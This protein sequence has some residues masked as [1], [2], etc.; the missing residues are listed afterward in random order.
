[1]SGLKFKNSKDGVSRATINV[2]FRLTAIE[3]ENLKKLAEADGNADWLGWFS[4][5]AVYHT[6]DGITERMDWINE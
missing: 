2:E 6:Q 1:M 4:N 5:F 3:I